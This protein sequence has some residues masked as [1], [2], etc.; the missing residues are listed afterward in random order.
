[1]L[2]VWRHWKDETP[3]NTLDPKLRDNYSNIEVIKCIRI[4]LLCVQENPDA[5]PTM[6]TIVSYLSSHSIELPSPQE[7]T[8]FLYHRMDQTVAHESSSRQSTNN[9]IPSSINEMSISK[10]YPR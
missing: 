4:G 8:F 10:F 6:L 2:Q 3:L 1:L 5:R 9:S 7:P